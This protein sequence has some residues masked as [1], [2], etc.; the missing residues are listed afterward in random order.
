MLS[1][2][3][4]HLSLASHLLLQARSFESDVDGRFCEHTSL[5]QMSLQL[6]SPAKEH[7]SI[8]DSRQSGAA[9][10]TTMETT[11][12]IAKLW[13]WPFEEEETT[14]LDPDLPFVN[15]TNVTDTIVDPTQADKITGP[16]ALRD[17]FE[18]E[19]ITNTTSSTPVVV[20]AAPFPSPAPPAASILDGAEEVTTT[21]TLPPLQVSSSTTTTATEAAPYSQGN[22]NISISSPT[23]KPLKN[24]TAQEVSALNQSRAQATLDCI[25]APWSEW[26]ACGL[27]GSARDGGILEKVQQRQRS[28]LTPQSLGGAAC[29]ELTEIQD[30]DSDSDTGT[31]TSS[32]SD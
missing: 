13:A 15:L 1:I 12:V 14:T 27:L 8:K 25:A 6:A 22:T 29:P 18:K 17:A 16:A 30:C 20:V 10:E 32:A 24:L 23:L 19:T 26:S 21:T 7:I 11:T 3:A 4:V 2:F 9:E 5:L 28:I 31:T